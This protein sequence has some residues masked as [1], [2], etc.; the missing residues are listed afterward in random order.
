MKKNIYQIKKNTLLLTGCLIRRHS[1][2]LSFFCL[3]SLLTITSY[4]Q[5]IKVSGVVREASS[6]LPLTGTTLQEKGTSNGTITDI[7][8]MYSLEVSEGAILVAS[9]VGYETKEIAVVN[10]TIVDF[11]LDQDITALEE[12]IVVGYGTQ[13]AT[14]VISSVVQVNTEDLQIEK[15]PVTNTLSALQGAVPGLV[16]R[17]NNGSPGSNPDLQI[18]GESTLNNDADESQVLVIIDNFEGS[19]ADI[20]PQT[21][22]SVSVL[23]DASAVAIY[24]ARGANGVLL[25]TTK[26]TERSKRIS[27]SYNFSS[28]VQLKP[29]LPTTLN[30]LEYMQFQN[31]VV[32]GTW[33]QDSLNRA[34]NGFYPE[35]VWANELYENQASLQSH[36]LTLTGGSKNTGYLMSASYLAQDGLAVGDDQ[37]RR[38]NLRLK[39][40]TD[41]TDWLT[42]GANALISN[43][44][45]KSVPVT[46]GSSVR[47][48]PF[49]PVQSE[50]G[51]W[52]SNGT[53][54]DR[55]NVVAQAASGSFG[56]FDLD[57]INLQLYTQ[58][59]PVKGL[60]FE[61]RVSVIK[62]NSFTRDWTNDYDVVGLDENDP[63]SYT[64]PDSENRL[65]LEASPDSRELILTSFTSR[66]IRSLTSLTY[67]L[68]KGK[69]RASAFVAMQTETGESQEFSTGRQSFLF[70]NIVALDQ[71]QILS[72]DNSLDNGFGNTESRGGNATTLSFLGRLNYTFDSKYIV[73][74]SFRRDG[75]SFFTE[76]N[77]WAFFPSMAVGWV[78]SNEKFLY[79]VDFIDLFKFKAS[80]GTSGDDSGL[81]SATQQLV[82]FNANGYPIGGT[83]NSRLNVANVVNP[84]LIWETATILNVG[85]DAS[86]FD[87][88]LRFNVDYFENERTNILSAISNTAFEFGFGDAQGNPYDVKS[89][90]W[91]YSITH[92]NSIGDF[93]YSLSANISDYDNEITRLTEDAIGPNFQEGQSIRDRFGYVTDGFFDDEE[94]IN[95]HFADDGVTLIDQTGVGTSYVGGF[96]YVDQIT[97]DTDEDGIPDARDGII[98]TD[99]RVVLEENSAPNLIFGFNL[100]AGY[101][102]FTLSARFY[103]V[104]D[105]NQW[106]NSN[107]SSQ[108]FLGGGVPFTYQTDVWSSTNTDA[109]FPTPRNLDPVQGYS[110]GVDRLIIDAEY[111]KLQNITLNYQLGQQVLENISFIKALSVF[112]SAENLGVIWTNSPLYE[113]GWDPELGNDAVDYPL[114]F[115]TSFGIN[116]KL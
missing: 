44:T 63:D 91:E 10:Q 59:N 105:N 48:L 8:G 26:N 18:R 86:L 41:V 80:Y 11:D 12:L 66:Q 20:D 37:F 29:D 24:G 6:G 98:N 103:G 104:F 38:L 22:Q 27:I 60:T 67:D 100:S 92:K 9:F 19:L 15:R 96:K 68:E 78:V 56:E 35:T 7:D 62:T 69:H 102:N 39:I 21:I 89:W 74:A 45:D 73:E 5:I 51:L 46:T 16:I 106:L 108:P 47:G 88:K 23:K 54:D 36:N 14:N 97:V 114:P 112:V 2:L 87:G 50:D 30:S 99:D 90:G 84:D 17:N 28:S 95:N 42:V 43:R 82:S 65:F 58:L 33:G 81:G 113:Q 70:D 4:A 64:N 93:N 31:S 83:V 116:V 71:G 53:T 1:V 34:A 79:D 107:N 101:K 75:T 40:D 111:L 76:Q 115:T 55:A 110:T 32:P 25:I 57:R 61:E 13:E 94:E 72:N 77:R 49:F 52:V 85:V 3:F 109:L